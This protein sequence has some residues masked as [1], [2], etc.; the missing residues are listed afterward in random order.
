MFVDRKKTLREFNRILKPDGRFFAGCCNS[1]GRWLYKL[2]TSCNPMDFK[3]KR[4]KKC[5]Q[6]FLSGNTLD[7]RPNY[8]SLKH[9]NDICEQFGFKLISANYDRCI[10]LTDQGIKRPM[11]PPRFLF[12]ENNIEF[13]GEKIRSVD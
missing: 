9:C 11:F 12:F 13:I 7:S 8:T 4:L 1:R 10:D 3:Y 5:L 2:L 6:T